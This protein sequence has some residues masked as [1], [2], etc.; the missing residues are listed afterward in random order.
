MIIDIMAFMD[1]VYR[2]LA[3]INRRKIVYWL[4][5]G[6][7]NVSQ[8]EKKLEISQATV[9]SHLAILK[10]SGLISSRVKGKERIYKLNVEIGKSFVREL[11][12]LMSLPVDYSTEEIIVRK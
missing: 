7:M 3:E 2:A 6:E 1:R 11:N 10:K 9:S 5:M 12:R 4:S 8:I